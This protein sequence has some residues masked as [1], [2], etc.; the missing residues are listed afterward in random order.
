LQTFPPDFKW[1]TALERWGATNIREM[2]GEAVPPMF[3]R[4]HGLA[5]VGLLTGKRTI[6]NLSVN[7]DRVRKARSWLG[8]ETRLY[9]QLQLKANAR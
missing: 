8:I 4:Q 6:A 7:D 9:E 1:G 2:I 3:T 5:L